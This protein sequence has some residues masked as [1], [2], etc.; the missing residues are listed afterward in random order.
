MR[1]TD[2]MAPICI[3]L[4][5]L[6]RYYEN[7]NHDRPTSW[8]TPRSV[9]SLRES[10]FISVS[11]LISYIDTTV[12]KFAPDAFLDPYEY[13]GTDETEITVRKISD[14]IMDRSKSET[15]SELSLRG[16]IRDT[17]IATWNAEDVWLN[18]KT[19]LTQYVIKRY[20]GTADGV[21]REIPGDVLSTGYDPRRRP[22]YVML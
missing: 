11:V 7:S 13:F 18:S 6:F 19:E 3:G 15:H 10:L 22:W 5:R 20:I 14:Y 2:S 9:I 16:G 21:F 17:V 1:F 12:V 4:L 8:P